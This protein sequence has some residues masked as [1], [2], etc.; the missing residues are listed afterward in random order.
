[1]VKALAQFEKSFNTKEEACE[2]IRKHLVESGNT[3]IELDGRFTV[4][5][6]IEDYNRINDDQ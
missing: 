1:M 6:T 2:A 5:G 4:T 3:F